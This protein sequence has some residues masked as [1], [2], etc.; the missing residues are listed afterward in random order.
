[1]HEKLVLAVGLLLFQSFGFAQKGWAQEAD[2]GLELSIRKNFGYQA[3]S[4]IQGSFSLE[5]H[6]PGEMESVAFFI[7]EEMIGDVG[8][9]P[10]EIPF[11]TSNYPLG[12]HCITAAAELPGGEILVAKRLCFTF[13]SADSVKDEVTGFVV[14]L[15]LGLAALIFGGTLLT[16]LITGRKSGFKLGAYGAAGGCVCPRCALPYTR[17][18]FSPNLIM[19]KLERCPHCGKW[20]IVRR[21]TA[22]ELEQAEEHYW[23][24]H[25]DLFQPI[26]NEGERLRKQIE[27]S[28]YED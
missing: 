23:G 14:P 26:E 8:K 10:F 3:G 13:L 25:D 5:A 9:A 18:I 12:E 19:G 28:R 20:A 27:D 4:Q 22:I 11:S 7:D 21:A 6:G 16:S 15:V 17:H 24:R 1:M 2:S